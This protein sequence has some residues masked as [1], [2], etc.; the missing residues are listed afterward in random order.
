MGEILD[1]LKSEGYKFGDLQVLRYDPKRPDV[2]PPHSSASSTPW[3]KTPVAAP[4]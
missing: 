3:L 2:F 4:N 1:L